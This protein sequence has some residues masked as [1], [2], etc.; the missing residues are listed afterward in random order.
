MIQTLILQ[1]YGINCEYETALACRQA[2]S[3]VTLTHLHTFLHNQISL[4]DYHLIVFP[5]GFS[6]GDELGAGK[7]LANRFSYSTK[8][9]ARLRDFVQSGRCILGIC[10]GF[11][12]LVKLGLLPGQLEGAPLAQEV[13]LMANV[14]HRFENRWIYH[15]TYPS[16]CVFTQKTDQLYLPVRHAEGKLIFKSRAVY[17]RVKQ[18][19]QIVFRYST[20]NGT[21]ATTYPENPN[22]SF[23]AI[24]GLCDPTGR[25]LGMMAHPEAYI[26]PFQNPQWTHKKDQ[27]KRGK[28]SFPSQGEGLILFQNSINYLKEHL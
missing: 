19:N 6:F 9:T 24:A 20:A 13:S 16:S 23:D 4:S 25:I 5:G 11:Q 10:N 7:A 15:K 8:V 12:L 21:L 26:S 1:G 3:Q 18:H 17:S 14:N 27:A 22:G 28:A 2:G